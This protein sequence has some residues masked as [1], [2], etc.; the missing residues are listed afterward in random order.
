MTRRGTET[1]RVFDDRGNRV[2]DVSGPFERITAIDLGADGERLAVGAENGGLFEFA[3]PG[4]VKQPRAEAAHRGIQPELHAALAGRGGWANY[5]DHF[6][7]RRRQGDRAGTR[8][9]GRAGRPFR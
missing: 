2:A 7:P 5:P 1:V 4:G 3:L 8:R 9:G 6:S